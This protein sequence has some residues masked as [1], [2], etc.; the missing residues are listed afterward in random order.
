MNFVKNLSGGLGKRRADPVVSTALES[1]DGYAV[2]RS[3]TAGRFRYIMNIRAFHA[4]C[5]ARKVTSS[6]TVSRIHASVRSSSKP[7]GFRC[8]VQFGARKPSAPQ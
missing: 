5:T 6:P 3:M 7:S 2:N 4:S 1:P 8:V